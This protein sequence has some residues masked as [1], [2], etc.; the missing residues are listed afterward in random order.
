MGS[1]TGAFSTTLSGLMASTSY[2]VRAYATNSE[3]TS[4]GDDEEFTTTAT[5]NDTP[6]AV[7]TG[8][9]TDISTTSATVAGNVTADG[10]K[11]VTERGVVYSTNANP[12][13]TDNKVMAASGGTGE[14]SA[15]LT[16]LTAGTAYH[17]RIRDQ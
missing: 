17:V 13:A 11:T 14:F 16:G 3:G 2:Y 12:T 1:G 8:A 6:P 10:G 5:H 4:Y 9:V 15:S 7:T